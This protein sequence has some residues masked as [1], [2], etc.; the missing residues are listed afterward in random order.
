VPFWISGSRQVL[1]DFHFC[2]PC[3]LAP[4]EDFEESQ[5][6]LYFQNKVGSKK[7]TNV[8]PTPNVVSIKNRFFLTNVFS[9]EQRR[10]AERRPRLAVTHARVNHQSRC[11]YKQ[12]SVH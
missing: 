6:P 4:K 7:N 9:V 2:A 11:G 10:G 12:K 5:P 3:D 1:L 8:I